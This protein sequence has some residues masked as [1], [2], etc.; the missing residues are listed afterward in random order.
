MI[1]QGLFTEELESFSRGGGGRS[2]YRRELLEKQSRHCHSSL[3]QTP[4]IQCW[5]PSSHKSHRGEKKKKKD[6]Q[7]WFVF[8]SFW[9]ENLNE[10]GIRGI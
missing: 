9:T 1:R 8:D 2:K 10:F 6:F 7:L 5:S 4:I 3:H